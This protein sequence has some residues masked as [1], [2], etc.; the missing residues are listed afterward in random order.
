MPADAAIRFDS[1]C[2]RYPTGTVALQD[3]DLTVGRGEVVALVGPSGC[4]KSTA[5]RIAAGLEAPSRGSVAVDLV[6]ATRQP[7]A[8]VFQDAT[9]LP[10]R[11]IR[12]NVALP[13]ELR[14]EPREAVRSAVERALERVGLTGFGDDY[15]RELSGGMRMRASLARALVTGPEILLLD[16]PFGALDEL[17]RQRLQEE[18]L[19][20]AAAYRWTVVFVTHS[21]FEAVYLADRVA[22]MTPR[23]GRIATVIDVGLPRPRSEDL[24][25][26]AAFAAKVGEVARALR[27]EHA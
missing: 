9:L 17:T 6:G 14:G 27:E 11:R 2:L 1:V 15:P 22:V 8:F 19:Q 21:V 26:D 10:W 23:P 20:L 12:D 13:L 24:R 18:L 3:V 4:G 16:E 5:L 7:I 25:S